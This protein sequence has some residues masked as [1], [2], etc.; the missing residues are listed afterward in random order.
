MVAAKTCLAMSDG[1]DQKGNRGNDDATPTIPNNDNPRILIAGAGIMGIS[2]AYFLARRGVPVTL[3]DPVGIAPCASSKAGGFLAKDWRDGTPLEQLQR[4]G[5]D[6]HQELANELA[7]DTDY[8]RLTCSAVSVDETKI[9]QKPPSLKVKN[10]EWVDRA[11]VGS[12]SMGE[13]ETIAQVHPRK[14]CEAMWKFCEE[15]GSRLKVGRVVNVELGSQNKAV[16]LVLLEDGTRIDVDKFLVACGPWSGEARGWFSGFD[17]SLPPITSVKCH[18]ILIKAP[19]VLNQAV[20]FESDGALGD[21]DLEVYPRRDGD[22]Y[23]NGFQGAEDLIEEEPGKEVVENA[24]ICKLKE[25]MNVSSQLAGIEPHTKQ[26]CYW[27]ETP[28]GRP[29]IGKIPEISNA[30]IATGHSVWG[31]LQG[32]SSGKAMSELILDGKSSFS[33][34]QF[35]PER[36]AQEKIE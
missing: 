1:N 2:T 5:F 19:S 33:L 25:A 7:D 23:V 16:C 35:R 21:G 30:Y 10:V 11:V 20:F 36:F 6:L 14:L 12:V 24:A 29:L 3:V 34:E 32:P 15:N 26:V 18:S 9:V 31:I 27:P 17:L 8:R 13:Q 28:D 22:A 4:E